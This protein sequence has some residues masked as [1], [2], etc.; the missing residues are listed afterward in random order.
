MTRARSQQICCQDTPYYHCISRVVRKAF[1]C[2]FDKTTQ[3]DF[4]HRRQRM[5]DKLAE[6]AHIC[7]VCLRTSLCYDVNNSN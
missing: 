2:G 1:L 6:I 4:E 7:P 3:Q 5:L